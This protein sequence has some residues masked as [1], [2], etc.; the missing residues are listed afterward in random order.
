MVLIGRL[1]LDAARLRHADRHG[2]LWLDRGRLSVEA[3][4]LRFVTAGGALEP[5]DYQIPHQSLSLILL[6]PGSSLTHDALRLLAAHGAG[7]AAIGEGGVRVYTAP[8]LGSRS[9][10]LARRQALLWADPDSRMDVAR[11]MYALRMGEVVAARSIE[12][13][14]GLEGDRV[15][16]AYRRRAEEFGIE[17]R[18]RRYD[19]SNP[20][21]ADPPNQAINHASSAVQAAAAIAVYATGAIAQLGFV[22]EDAAHAFILDI[23]DLFRDDVTLGIAFGAVKEAATRGRSID[24]LVRRR[25]AEVFGRDDVIPRMID[26]VKTLLGDGGS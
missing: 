4:C 6:G 19:R 17:W 5:G 21:A 3:G 7:L 2:L 14:R 9:S 22:H 8:P 20:A 25:A 15:K 24:T 26:R 13:L 18:G 16:A 10:A 11:A 1:G 23:A 12:R